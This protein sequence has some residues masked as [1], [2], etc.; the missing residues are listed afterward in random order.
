MYRCYEEA[1]R[2]ETH[3]TNGPKAHLNYGGRRE[4]QILCST[5]VGAV[6]RRSRKTNR[7]EEEGGHQRE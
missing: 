2:L 1:N 3:S 6:G 5:L 4:E 7:A